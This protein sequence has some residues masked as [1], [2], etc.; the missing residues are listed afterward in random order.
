M[1]IKDDE[2]PKHRS[3]KDKR[4]WCGGKPGREHDPIWQH[5]RTIRNS[6]NVEWYDFTCQKCGKSLDTWWRFGVDTQMSNGVYERPEIGSREPLKR[7]VKDG[8]TKM[9]N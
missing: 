8:G 4:R 6:D 1:N 5:S 9:D 2:I 7:K 3:K